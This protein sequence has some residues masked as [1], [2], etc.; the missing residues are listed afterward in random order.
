MEILAPLYLW[1]KA[2]HVISVI[3]WMAGIFYLPRLFVRH[4]ENQDNANISA[5]L[6][7]ME[8][9]LY[10]VIMTPAMLASWIFA[11]LIIATGIPDIV[12]FW[13]AVKLIAVVSMTLFHFWCGLR[14]RDF[15]SDSNQHSHRYYR[16]ANEIPTLLMM[17]IVIMVIVKPFG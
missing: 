11:L 2:L 13:F 12:S 5:L 7:T 8:D 6:K 15:A 16:F 1:F 4:A 9:K 10:R 14:L 17:I 3:A